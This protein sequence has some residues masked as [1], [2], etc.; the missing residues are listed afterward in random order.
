MLVNL[1]F[2]LTFFLSREAKIKNKKKGT[3]SIQKQPPFLLDTKIQ[4]STLDSESSSYWY[5]F[6]AEG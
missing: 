1:T 2:F 5:Q 3:T 4:V 6:P